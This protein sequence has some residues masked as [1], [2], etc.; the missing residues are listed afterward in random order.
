MLPTKLDKVSFRMLAISRNPFQ[1]ASSRLTLVLCPPRTIE[2]LMT[3]DFIV[4]P[5]ETKEA[6]HMQALRVVI[7]TQGSR[8]DG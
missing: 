7:V 5:P 6:I 3:E 2:R 8:V 4:V 1:N